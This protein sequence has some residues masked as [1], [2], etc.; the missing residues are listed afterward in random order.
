MAICF[1]ITLFTLNSTKKKCTRVMQC[2]V[3]VIPL[4]DAKLRFSISVLRHSSFWP[5]F[6]ICLFC[7]TIWFDLQNISRAITVTI[8]KNNELKQYPHSR[9]G[10]TI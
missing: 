7:D 4:S 9:T 8:Q 3:D 5:T 2:L 10:I 6:I 1:K